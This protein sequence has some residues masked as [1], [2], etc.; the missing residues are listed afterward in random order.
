MGEDCTHS[1]SEFYAFGVVANNKIFIGAG[2]GKDSKQLITCEVY[3]ML[4]DEWQ[5]IASL[6]VP[7]NQGNMV[8]ANETMCVLGG[9]SRN[10][11]TPLV[12]CYD[13]EKD[14]WN[15]ETLIPSPKEI[16]C[17]SFTF[18]ASSLNVSNHL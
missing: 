17:R 5:F 7:R 18:K 9:H 3:N 11:F 2:V 12:E 8:L 14:Q 1:R 13:H 6:T 4:A 10:Y 15:E 16:R